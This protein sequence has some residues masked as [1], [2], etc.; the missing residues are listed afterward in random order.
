[1]H[2]CYVDTVVV[3]VDGSEGANAALAFAAHEAALRGAKLR[4]VCGWGVPATVYAS[5]FAPQADVAALLQ[6]SARRACEDALAEAR[7]LEPGLE[8][9][10]SAKEG[11]PATVLVDEA[12]DAA[13]LVVGSRGL[14]GFRSLLLGSVSY[15]VVHHAACPV[16]VVRS[17]AGRAPQRPER[18]VVGVD[19]SETATQALRWALDAAHIRDVAVE[20]V[21]AWQMPFVGGPFSA[22]AMDLSRFEDA[23]AD[24]LDRVVDAEDTS[25][26]VV[27]RTVAC[28]GAAEAILKAS[29]DADLV[30]VGC[31]GFSNIERLLLGSVS[32][33]VILHC[34][35]PVVV[36]PTAERE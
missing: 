23:A 4:I 33:Q 5:A 14:G 30:V 11:H 6:K 36:V 15:H 21:H 31:R 10:A 2:T 7:R 9:E 12:R 26:L 16:A 20:V 13:L 29:E 28:G 22:A 19:G 24:L 17:P 1:V 32:H 25:G 35:L 34:S 18:I 8:C 27:Q 3:G